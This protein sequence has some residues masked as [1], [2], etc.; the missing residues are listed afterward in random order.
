MRVILIIVESTQ[1]HQ[2]AQ[3]TS[4]FLF[5]DM[6]HIITDGTSEDILEKEFLAL[7]AEKE[8]FPPRLR[9]QYKDYSEWYNA[10]LQKEELK[11]Q[12]RY[13]LNELSGELPV[14]DIP[15]DYPRPLVQGIEGNMVNFSFNAGET[16]LLK[17]MARENGLTLYMT[18]LA[19]F[20][21]LLAKLSGLEDII[22]G[23]PIAA[24][25]HLDLSNVIGMLVNTLALRNYPSGEKKFNEFLAEIRERT[26]TAYENQE[27]PFEVLVE[28]IIVN[29]DAGR[30]PVFDVMFNLLNQ[31]DYQGNAPKQNEQNEPRSYEHIKGTSKFDLNLTAI[32]LEERILFTLEYS[33]RLFKPVTI[34][35]FIGYFKNILPVLAQDTALTLAEIEL[36]EETGKK[37]I[38][39]LSN[40]VEWSFEEETI[41]GWFAKQVSITPDCIALVGTN[42]PVRPNCLTYSQLDQQANRLAGLLIEKGVVPD[43]IIAIKLERSI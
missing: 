15:T 13:W 26:L 25:R 12:E 36:M 2:S 14:P 27:Y 23:T 31:A 6:H 32:D 4:R 19:L 7:M 37:E 28:K 3:S 43:D 24:R 10:A 11:H 8:L 5:I 21:I 1:L 41:H 9:L 42:L 38:L 33:T 16:T 34:E 35:R 17:A 40:G 30:N 29:R 22:I 18:L 39:R 20:N